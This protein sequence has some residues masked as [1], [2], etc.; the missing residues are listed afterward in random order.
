MVL[1]HVA[2]QNR[3]LVIISRGNNT[4]KHGVSVDDILAHST[5]DRG[6]PV[7]ACD[8]YFVSLTIR[9]QTHLTATLEAFESLDKN[10]LSIAVV[11]VCSLLDT[12]IYMDAEALDIWRAYN[13]SK[14]DFA[15]EY[16]YT[17]S[18]VGSLFAK[19]GHKALRLASALAILNEATNMIMTREDHLSESIAQL[20]DVELPADVRMDIYRDLFTQQLQGRE[21][22]L[23]GGKFKLVLSSNDIKTAIDWVDLSNK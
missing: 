3:F 12:H 19:S 8:A 9:L 5:A 17:M 1:K 7:V 6:T 16:M 10:M 13:T 4:L 20:R 15:D 23:D 21:A 18:N 22:S 14:M 11:V 2:S